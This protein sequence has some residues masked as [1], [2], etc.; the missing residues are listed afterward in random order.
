MP[1]SDGGSR[2]DTPSEMALRL[3]WVGASQ[4]AARKSTANVAEMADFCRGEM[5]EQLAGD[6]RSWLLRSAAA[7]IPAA[8]AR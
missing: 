7:G 4:E 2:M 3:R 5:V 6:S 1:D 8:D